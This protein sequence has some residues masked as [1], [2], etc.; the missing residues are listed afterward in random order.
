MEN[1]NKKKYKVVIRKK[2][3]KNLKKIPLIWSVR[4][5]KALDVLEINP[6]YGEKLWGELT[7]CYKIKVWPYRIIYR[8]IENKKIVH[9][10][11][12]DHRQGAYK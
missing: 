10:Q 1:L 6:F 7:G 3:E 2:A 11:R 12:I 9:I 5:I 4:I 8:V